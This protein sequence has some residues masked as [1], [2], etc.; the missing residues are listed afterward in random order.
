MT[1]RRPWALQAKAQAAAS[2]AAQEQQLREALEQ[3]AA[4]RGERDGLAQRLAASSSAA[5]DAGSRCEALTQQLA[6]SQQQ[7]E[8]SKVEAAASGE[9]LA[10]TSRQLQ[11]LQAEHAARGEELA[12]LQAEHE[13]R[14]A[15][16]S[17]LQVG[18]ERGGGEEGRQR[19]LRHAVGQSTS[20]GALPVTGPAY[21]PAA[22]AQ[23][24]AATS[25]PPPCAQGAHASVGSELASLSGAYTTRAQELSELQQALAARTSELATRDADLAA[26]T[27]ELAELRV[28][29]PLAA[30]SGAAIHSPIHSAPHQHK[31]PHC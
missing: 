28:R 3:L 27:A 9:Q 13:G 8:A 5:S 24:N 15:E 14:G 20:Q 11:Q 18:E 29:D 4:V 22:C 30:G 1:T 17:S 2:A 6:A 26:R 7:A 16:L 19:W 31:Q 25:P 10:A 21:S 12:A 23:I